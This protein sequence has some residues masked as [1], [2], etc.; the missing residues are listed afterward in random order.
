MCKNKKCAKYYKYI[1]EKSLPRQMAM[2]KYLQSVQK[3]NFFSRKTENEQ[4]LFKGIC[5]KNYAK[6]L[7][8][9]CEIC[10]FLLKAFRGAIKSQNPMTG[11]RPK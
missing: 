4:F 7:R 6:F 3:L 9:Y 2:L 11:S 8:K 1:F 10:F 5:A